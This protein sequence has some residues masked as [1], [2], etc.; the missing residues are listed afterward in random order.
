MMQFDGNVS[1]N[2]NS[3]FTSFRHRVCFCGFAGPISP[4][5]KQGVEAARPVSFINDSHH[6]VSTELAPFCS[7]AAAYN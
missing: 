4:N 7:I 6:K 2:T 3:D 5:F 1:M